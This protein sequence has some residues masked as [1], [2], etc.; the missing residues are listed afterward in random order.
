MD[1]WLISIATSILIILST[2]LLNDLQVIHIPWL[3]KNK[4]ENSE[5]IIGQ[6]QFVHNNVRR[7]SLNN[8]IWEDGRAASKIYNKDTLLTLD[9]SSAKIILDNEVE[10]SL[11]ENTLVFLEQEQTEQA[12]KKI[13]LKFEQGAL[14]TGRLSK[15]TTLETKSYSISA[16]EG[17][18]IEIRSFKDNF[19]LEVIDGAVEL[20][21]PE[22]EKVTRI[23]SGTLTQF[24]SDQSFEVN[25]VSLEMRVKG[26]E[27]ERV[28]SHT[29]PIRYPIQWEGPAE[30]IS[31]EKLGNEETIIPIRSDF[32]EQD[33]FLFP[34]T[35]Y[36]R[37]A[38]Q[39]ELSLAK[40]IEVRP[41]PIVHLISPLPRDRV[42]AGTDVSFKW[43]SRAQI[44]QFKLKLKNESDEK[45]F[46]AKGTSKNIRP[47]EVGQKHWEVI[48]LDEDGFEI[49]P[50]YSNPIFITP[51]PLSAPKLKSTSAVKRSKIEESKRSPSNSKEKNK[52]GTTDP[53]DS[54]KNDQKQDKKEEQG[55][56]KNSSNRFDLVGT[57]SA[58]IIGKS[59]AQSKKKS[60]KDFGQ[61]IEIGFA[62]EKVD[63]ADH[64]VIEIS[65]RSDFRDLLHTQKVKTT[66]YFWETTA[67]G[68]IYWR[69]AGGA[70]DGRMGLFSE[71]EEL[72][73]RDL[74]AKAK[75]ITPVRIS[76]SINVRKAPPKPTP[77]PKPVAKP[78]PTPTPEPI[79]EVAPTP[80]EPP[81]NR[82]WMSYGAAYV[83][84]ELEGSESSSG[85]FAGLQ[86]INGKIGMALDYFGSHLLY[87]DAEYHE[88]TWKE[89]VF[90]QTEG[91]PRLKETVWSVDLGAE[92]KDYLFNYGISFGEVSEVYRA[93]AE[94]IAFRQK[95]VYGAYVMVDYPLSRNHRFKTELSLRA[96][97]QVLEWGIQ[98]SWHV[99]LFDFEHFL[100]TLEPRANYR[101]IK[102]GERD[103]S[104]SFKGE[105]FL[106]IQ[107]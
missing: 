100:L 37:V 27:F 42:P 30:S 23:D 57:L 102:F 20:S 52:P 29:F 105:V 91:T 44:D 89:V 14:R 10:L 18:Q 85:E 83:V 3:S 79:V 4:I 5:A 61:R 15:N 72:N 63:G 34:G 73:M 104:S 65:K 25:E 86:L 67:E 101:Q 21:S 58:V 78:K 54:S 48:A 33:V 66:R 71:I 80:E 99:I 59:A 60:S 77:T 96:G 107:F 53:N 9:N 76:K 39:N 26:N 2:W 87:L 17:S 88:S 43:L 40:T 95:F 70:N 35:Y 13:R 74:R 32:S 46:E 82:F 51:R 92:Q 47:S 1:R 24:N 22:T 62:W 81:Q 36:V 49:P 12:D 11:S 38:G 19:E 45:S 28:Y 94:A 98:P 106:G 68:N 64:Y 103:F 41:A 56:Y 84:N 69:V 6:I 97:D 31:L 90:G 8:L 93:S 75:S 7:R 50:L 16:E 55:S